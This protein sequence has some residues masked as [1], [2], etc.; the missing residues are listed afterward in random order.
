VERPAFQATDGNLP[1]RPDPAPSG[2]EEG[3]PFHANDPDTGTP[4]SC[5]S[6]PEER[7]PFH[8]ND[9]DTR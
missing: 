5:P 9:P 8:A 2:P 1:T 7:P 6:G 4:G 3:P